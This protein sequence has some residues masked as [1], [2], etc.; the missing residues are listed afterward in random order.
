MSGS[1]VTLQLSEYSIVYPVSDVNGARYAALALQAKLKTRLGITLPVVSDTAAGNTEK[2]IRFQASAKESDGYTVRLSEKKLIVEGD[3]LFDFQDAASYIGENLA[4][5]TMVLNENYSHF[6]RNSSDALRQKT[7]SYRIWFHNVWGMNE[8]AINGVVASEIEATWQSD[9][10]QNAN[11]N[12]NMRDETAAALMLAYQPDIIGLA[13]YYGL[14]RTSNDFKN[15]L[16]NNG[17]SMA[18]IYNYDVCA[19][20]HNAM[21]IFYKASVFTFESG[22]YV[23]FSTGGNDPSKGFSIAVLKDKSTGQ[24]ICVVMTH[25]DTNTADSSNKSP[26]QRRIEHIQLI[27]TT[28]KAHLQN[29]GY[30]DIPVILGG[31]FNV[32]IKP[33]LESPYTGV[34]YDACQE[35]ETLGYSNM[36]TVAQVKNDRCSCHGYPTHVGNGIYQTGQTNATVPYSVGID[37]AY[38][39]NTAGLTVN[40]YLTVEDPIVTLIS[41]HWP[42]M[43]DF[44]VQAN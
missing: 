9:G 18:P 2:Q 12:T 6:A 5:T 21:P 41:D 3:D 23:D 10:T 19:D 14:F 31:D 40:R 36:R 32:Q 24:R 35:L 7:G 39:L 17:Y 25:L 38:A 27:N 4:N 33:M 29:K 22:E 30:G 26:T 34:T 28:V 1:T 20:G 13:E 42:Q 16:L 11:T 43:I 8:H 44:T 15:A 37:H